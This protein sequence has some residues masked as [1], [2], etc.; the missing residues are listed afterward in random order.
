MKKKL[1]SPRIDDHEAMMVIFYVLLDW[2]PM[3]GTSPQSEG[4][5]ELVPIPPTGARVARN[6][7]C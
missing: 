7:A 4:E 3:E 5:K 6:A 2:L 1:E